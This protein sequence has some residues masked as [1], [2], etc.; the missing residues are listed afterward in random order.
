MSHSNFKAMVIVFFSIQGVVMA[1]W[2]P[3]GQTVNHHYY[4]DIL[5]KLHEKMRRK[6]PVFW[7]KRW[8]FHQDNTPLH[9]VC[10]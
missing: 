10:L 1:V 8:I 4:I 5:T 9:N 6:E 2:E 3:S 7:R